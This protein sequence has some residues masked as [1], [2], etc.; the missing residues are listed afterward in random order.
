MRPVEMVAVAVH[1]IAVLIYKLDGSRHKDDGM[2]CWTPPPITIN[3]CTLPIIDPYPTLFSV[4]HYKEHESYPD[5]LA[6]SVGYWAES[7]ILGGVT[8][9]YRG[10]AN[11]EV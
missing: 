3:G 6:D 2:E 9:F 11:P 10:P 4:A 7:R 1:Q 5:G 8:L